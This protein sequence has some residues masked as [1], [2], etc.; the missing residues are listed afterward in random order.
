VNDDRKVVAHPVTLAYVEEGLAVIDGIAP[1]A[2]IVVEGAQNLRPGSVVGEAKRS[3]PEAEQ[4][5]VKKG[6]RMREPGKAP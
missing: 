5:E 1:G 6:D 2:R 3:A 4:G